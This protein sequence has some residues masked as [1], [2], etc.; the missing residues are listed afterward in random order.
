MRYASIVL[1]SL[2]KTAILPAILVLQP[3]WSQSSVINK[4]IHSNPK[5]QLADEDTMKG[6]LKTVPGAF[7]ELQQVASEEGITPIVTNI[8]V[9]WRQT[10]SSIIRAGLRARAVKKTRYTCTLNLS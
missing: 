3:L 7:E 10:K 4:M 1:K 2:S 9:K 6:W 5:F 8:D